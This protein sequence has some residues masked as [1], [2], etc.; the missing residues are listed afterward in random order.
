M[1]CV[2]LL[3]FFFWFDS[4]RW[5]SHT[6]PKCRYKNKTQNRQRWAS[7]LFCPT[8]TKNHLQKHCCLGWVGLPNIWL[9]EPTLRHL[10]THFVILQK[11]AILVFTRWESVYGYV[12][13]RTHDILDPI[14]WVIRPQPRREKV[15]KKE[16]NNNKYNQRRTLYILPRIYGITENK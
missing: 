12:L 2:F 3:F 16:N 8:R 13:C 10:F 9:S 6:K 15:T 4:L 14:S 11:Y 7:L 5:H 1:L